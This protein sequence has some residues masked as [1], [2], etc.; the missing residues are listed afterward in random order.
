MVPPVWQ[1]FDDQ[2]CSSPELMVRTCCDDPRSMWQEFAPVFLIDM[3]IFGSSVGPY[4]VLS[5]TADSWIWSFVH[6]EPSAVDDEADEDGFGVDRE[7]APADDDAD[8]EDED[9][10]DEDS[11]DAEAAAPGSAEVAPPR[12]TTISTTTTTMTRSTPTTVAR[13]RQ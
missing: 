3:A 1:S 9:R 2:Y 10:D 11:R 5:T 4:E 12:P 7:D 6:V 8:D 13:R